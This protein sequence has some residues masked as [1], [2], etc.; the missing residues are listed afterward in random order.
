[1]TTA[2]CRRGARHPPATQLRQRGQAS[3]AAR[4]GRSAWNCLPLEQRWWPAVADRVCSRRSLPEVVA[5]G[6]ADIDRLRPATGLNFGID[7]PVHRRVALGDCG[8]ADLR[9]WAVRQ[10]A[11]RRRADY[12]QHGRKNHQ[13][14]H[15]RPP[16]S[17]PAHRERAFEESNLR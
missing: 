15:V 9:P 8:I 11:R 17:R 10:G 7:L 13:S 6:W 1:M 4:A 12:G 2:A 5:V 16:L 14:P 3:R